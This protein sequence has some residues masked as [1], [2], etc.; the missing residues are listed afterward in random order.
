MATQWIRH[1]PIFNGLSEEELDFIAQAMHFVEFPA[2]SIIFREDDSGDS[3]YILVEGRVE[4]VKSLGAN[5]E[6]LMDERGPGEIFGELSLF[7]PERQ[8]TASARSLSDSR[9]LVMTHADFNALL[10]RNPNLAMA[11]LRELSL[12]M[13]DSDRAMIRDLQE[14]NR[15]LSQAYRELQAAQAELLKKEI[16]ERELEVARRI[17]ESILPVGMPRLPGFD[18]GVYMSPAQVVGGDFYDFIPLDEN[19]YGLAVGNVSD[20]GIPA[21][22]LMAVT[23]TLLR[24]EADRYETPKDVLLGVHR[25]LCAMNRAGVFVAVFYGVLDVSTRQFSFAR[26]GYDT[27]LWLQ[28]DGMLVRL[29]MGMA[30]PLGT[31]ED[32]A[33]EE[34]SLIFPAGST[35]LL[36]SDGVTETRNAEGMFFG[37]KRLQMIARAHLQGSAQSLCDAIFNAL[38][39][40]RGNI[41]Q[42]E[43]ITL[44]AIRSLE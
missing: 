35:L 34:Q 40:F 43:D 3:L 30:Q 13:R 7:D 36:K 25:H 24:A 19:R 44:L 17:Q 26:A 18:F 11:M 37:S 14:K 27:P 32:P 22:I 31:L 8:R 15:Q 20:K 33:L 4:I 2:N 1:V 39:D 9:M 12:R 28:R 5:G 16:L 23:L 42:F 38:S 10:Q 29:G 6:Y 21:A 41:P